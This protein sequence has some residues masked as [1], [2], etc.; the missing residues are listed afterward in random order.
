MFIFP[1]IQVVQYKSFSVL[2]SVYSNFCGEIRVEKSAVVHT[3]YI[4]TTW[5]EFTSPVCLQNPHYQEVAQSLQCAKTDKR[6]Q[7]IKLNLCP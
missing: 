5:I 2:S 4:F 6:I 3:F 1:V 7:R